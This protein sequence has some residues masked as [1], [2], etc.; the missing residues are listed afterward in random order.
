MLVGINFIL[1]L[2]NSE[3]RSIGRAFGKCPIES[4]TIPASVSELQDRWCEELSAQT[5][6]IISPNNPH[7]R[8]V[9]DKFIVGKSNQNS[10]EYDIL[11]FARRDITRATIPDNIKELAAC[12]FNEC[13]SL[14]QVEFSSNSKLTKIGIASF[15]LSIINRITIPKHV[16]EIGDGAF[17]T[18]NHLETVEFASD[19]ADG[20]ARKVLRLMR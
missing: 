11:Y 4:I 14:E 10:D 6:I 17:Y 18:C 3:L 2:P 12:C 13:T 5:I 20:F 7:F 9:D 19:S 15:A 8:L 16:K 1:F